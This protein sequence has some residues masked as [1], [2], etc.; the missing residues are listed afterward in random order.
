MSNELMNRLEQQ[1]YKYCEMYDNNII[2]ICKEKNVGVDMNTL[3]QVLDDAK[4]RTV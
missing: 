3:K 4:H 2:A 1:F